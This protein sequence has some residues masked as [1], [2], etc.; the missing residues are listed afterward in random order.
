MAA[1][2]AQT[3]VARVAARL[4][5]P[6][7][8]APCVLLVAPSR[9]AFAQLVQFRFSEADLDVVVPQPPGR[10]AADAATALV[11]LDTSL[12]ET[13][14]LLDRLKLD[15]ATNAIPA[16]ALF[17]RGHHTHRPFRLRIQADLELIEPFQIAPFFAAADH[18]LA[19]FAQSRVPSSL[20][21][22]C[23]FPSSQADLDRAAGIAAG[24]FR[25]SSLPEADQAS[26]LAAFREAVGNAVQHGNRRDPVKTVRV[27]YY[28]DARRI[29]VVVR[30]EGEGFNS[31][32]YLRQADEGDA[33][34]AARTRHRQGGQG[35]LGILMII[36]CTD[37]VEYNEKGNV[38]TFT[39]LL[40]P[41]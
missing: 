14:P 32:P 38:V 39:K 7:G 34:Q 13:E 28:Q 31:R 5:L 6:A 16:I 29:T 26:L 35:G 8:Q 30:D 1:P 27:E 25:T 18:L 2:P 15:P 24:L 37:Q 12:P 19:R 41:P 22:R 33:A 20:R 4:G 9:D 3:L 17:P 23:I 21:L 10:A 40:P 36:R 11:I